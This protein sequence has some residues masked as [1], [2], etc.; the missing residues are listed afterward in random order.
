MNKIIGATIGI[1]LIA[2]ELIISYLD[3]NTSKYVC[4]KCG[5]EILKVENL[6]KIVDGKK[7]LDKVSFTVL[8][9]DKICFLANGTSFSTET[10]MYEAK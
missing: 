2:V 9:G 4:N 8:K 5:K 3:Y 1:V 10:T 7:I 6:T